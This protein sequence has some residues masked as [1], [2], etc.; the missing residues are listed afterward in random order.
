MDL[1]KENLKKALYLTMNNQV[2]HK[3]LVD[4]CSRK[5]AEVYSENDDLYLDEFIEIAKDIDAQWEL[6]LTNTFSLSELQRIDLNRVTM[7]K[8]WLVRWYYAI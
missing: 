4:W 8:D 2:L 3:E 6:H 5:L 1:T 7:P